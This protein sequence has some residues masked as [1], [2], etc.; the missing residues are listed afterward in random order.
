MRRLILFLIRRHLGLKKG[1]LFQFANQKSNAVYYFDDHAIMK[2]WHHITTPSSVSLN[3]LL[4][5]ECEIK[6]C[7]VVY[8]RK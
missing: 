5:P 3:W 8:T 1:E 4:D 2:D 6:K 7:A